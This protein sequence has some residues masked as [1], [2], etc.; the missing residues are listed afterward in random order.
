MRKINEINVG[1]RTHQIK[2]ATTTKISKTIGEKGLF[3]WLTNN[4]TNTIRQQN[5]A[6]VMQNVR[7]LVRMDESKKYTLLNN[8]NFF[9]TDISKL[10]DNANIRRMINENKQLL[11]NGKIDFTLIHDKCIIDTI[12]DNTLLNAMY[13]Y[14]LD[15]L[16]KI[17][18]KI[19]IQIAI[20]QSV[21]AEKI[22]SKSVNKRIS[23]EINNII[24]NKSEHAKF[25]DVVE[26]TD[27]KSKKYHNVNISN[28]GDMN[29]YVT[30]GMNKPTEYCGI[31]FNYNLFII[32]KFCGIKVTSLYN[33]M[34]FGKD[35]IIVNEYGGILF[36]G[37]SVKYEDKITAQYRMLYFTKISEQL[38]YFPSEC[39]ECIMF[40]KDEIQKIFLKQ[41]GLISKFDSK[42]LSVYDI[43]RNIL[44][45]SEI[46]Y[47]DIFNYLK[48][49]ITSS[50]T[51]ENSIF[52]N[53]PYID[54]VEVNKKNIK[55]L[56][57]ILTCNGNRKI[58]NPYLISP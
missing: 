8:F 25:T 15:H 11:I 39:F 46:K 1:I 47:I 9:G 36:A 28:F 10:D 26:Y 12:T 49:N 56:C 38:S 55:I 16:D 7:A 50:V 4:E 27:V 45:I 17:T 52:V 34:E 3:K 44:Q 58:T 51:D 24:Y 6:I 48:D 33:K 21:S 2:F 53:F 30:N 19:D 37:S 35:K 18:Q 43:L 13:N 23:T 41:L 31:Y 57:N 32:Y 54:T 40:S 29:I 14:T 20:Q 5:Y 22:I 42:C